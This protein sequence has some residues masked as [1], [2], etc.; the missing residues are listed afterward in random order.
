MVENKR[1]KKGGYGKDMRP[2]TQFFLVVRE[3]GQQS[4]I[5]NSSIGQYIEFDVKT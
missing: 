4:R 1:H 5:N 2:W 3:V